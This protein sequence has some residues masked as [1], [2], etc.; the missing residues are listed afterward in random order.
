[1]H[2]LTEVRP[3]RGGHVRGGR[4]AVEHIPTGRF[5]PGEGSVFDRRLPEARGGHVPS[6]S[7]L[8]TRRTIRSFGAGWLSVAVLATADTR[9]SPPAV[10][11]SRKWL[12]IMD[13]F[14]PN[15]SGIRLSKRQT[16]SWPS[17]TSTR[18]SPW[19]AS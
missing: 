1:E 10:K 14:H 11:T 13:L 12:E 8:R 18:T 5:Q 19:G 3:L 17:G 2:H 9:S 15:S 4:R 16:V 7:R 6:S